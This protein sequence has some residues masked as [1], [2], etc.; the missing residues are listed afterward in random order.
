MTRKEL[1]RKKAWGFL[2]TN[3]VVLP[4]AGSVMAGRK[5][6]YLQA[7][8]ALA[9]LGLSMWF[10]WITLREWLVV[11]EVTVPALSVLAMGG[12]GLMLVALAWLWSLATGLSVLKEVERQPE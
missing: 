4:G 9:G 2:V 5:V 10:S 7:I 11:R 12:V 1:E 3:L 8:L 6:G